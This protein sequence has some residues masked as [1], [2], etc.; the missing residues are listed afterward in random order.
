MIPC[1][2]LVC[3]FAGS[4]VA[5]VGQDIYVY[6]DWGQTGPV[7]LFRFPNGEGAP[8]SQAF[9]AFGA[10]TDA[11]LHIQ[12]SYGGEFIEGFPAEDIWLESWDGLLIPCNGGTTVD[13]DTDAVGATF[14]AAPL[15]AGGHCD[16]GTGDRL[17]IKVNG[18]VALDG[19]LHDFSLN[20]PDING[21]LLVNLAD[22]GAFSTDYYSGLNPYRSDFR[23]DGAVNLGDIGILAQAMG[24]ACP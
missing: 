8:F 7:S 17:L 21:D 9:Q 6:P 13:Q 2:F 23:W 20:S 16:A 24:A 12:F 15:R 19:I 3:L 22:I 14:W 4:A 1:F 10:E 5:G 18:D 11:T